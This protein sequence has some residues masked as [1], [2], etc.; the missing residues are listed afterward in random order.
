MPANILNAIRNIVDFKDNDLHN[1][2]STYLNRINVVGQQLE[3]YARDAFCNAFRLPQNEKRIKYSEVFSYQAN[4]NNPPD[5]ILCNGDA[6]EVKKIESLKA[7]LALNNS[8]PKDVLHWDDKRITED[9]RK[10]EKEKWVAKDIFYTVGSAQKG[11]LKYLFFVHGRCYAARREVYEDKASQLKKNVEDFVKGKGWEASTTTIE[12]G[13][14]SRIDPLGITTFR[15]RGMWEIR[16]PI[17]VF[18]DVY[19]L[20]SRQDF[21]L[22]ALMTRGKFDSFLRSDV[23]ALQKGDI[24]IKDVKIFNPNNTAQRMDAKLIESGW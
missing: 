23:D 3:F 21:S 10:C 16:N 2:A 20:D 22:I 12:L 1:Y 7:A 14:I 8:P 15:V 5:F 17:N 13:R 11:R 18:E 6:F 19:K 4:Q 9:C 24:T